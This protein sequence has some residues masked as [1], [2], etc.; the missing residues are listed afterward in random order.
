[1]NNKSI[2]LFDGVCNLCNGVVN[3]LIDRDKKDI[4]RFDSLQ[5]KQSQE[6]IKKYQI[7]VKNLESI[8]LI[9]DSEYYIKSTAAIKIF[10]RLGGLWSLMNV[11]Y[12]I[13]RFFRDQVY[14]LIA[15]NRYSIF[16]R[17][18]QCRMPNSDLKAKFLS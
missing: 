14:M 13:P 4:F 2:I 8:V 9:E 12:V 5:S 7:Q 10:S 18:D 17:S 6:L 1:M 3:F 15:N 16:G 11:F